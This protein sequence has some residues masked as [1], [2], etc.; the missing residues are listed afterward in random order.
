LVQG[1]R[2]SDQRWVGHDPSDIADGIAPKIEL[3]ADER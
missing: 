2:L 3:A 1:N